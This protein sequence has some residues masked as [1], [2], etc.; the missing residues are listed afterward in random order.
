M[1]TKHIPVVLGTARAD[2]KSAGVA[3]AVV[4]II[5]TID[6]TS[7]ELVDVKDHVKHAVTTPPWGAGGANETP[8]KW[9]EIVQSAHALV[10][11]VPEYNHSFPGELKLLLDSLWDDYNGKAVGL[12]G[13]SK[14]TL[15][16]AR[17]VDHL[18]QVL[19]ELKLHPVKD[20]V[21]ISKVNEALADN[22]MFTNEKTPGYVV[23]MI[24]TISHLSSALDKLPTE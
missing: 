14:G 20:A 16:A 22:G 13:V 11:V 2:R 5:N 21:H 17:V 9:K 6:D 1:E 3:N 8:T 18:K 19:I 10:L 15:G 24:K 7:T 23:K 12:V 4:K